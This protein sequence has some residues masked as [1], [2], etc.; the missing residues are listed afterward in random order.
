METDY[1]LAV[2][3]DKKRGT[4]TSDRKLAHLQICLEHDVQARNN[5]TGLEDVSFIHHATTDLNIDEID[6]SVELFN[7]KLDTPLIISSMTGGHSFAQ[8]LNAFLSQAVEQTKIGMGVG[9]QRAALENE[10]VR[11]SFNVVR[12]K[13]PDSLIIGNIGAGQIAQGLSKSQFQ[14]II[15]MISADAVAV[16]FNPL[17]E[18]IQPEGDVL[19]GGLNEKITQLI[20]DYHQVPIIAKEVGS[21]FSLHDITQIKEFGFKAIDIQGVGGTSW[22]G[23]ESIRTT[24]PLYKSTG[25]VFWDWGIPTVLSTILAK[26]HFK[27]IVI[28][29]GGI[30]N[31]LDIAKLIALGADAAGIALPFLFE[32]QK[33][34]VDAIIDKIQEISYQLRLACFLTGSPNLAN[35]RKVPLMITGKT[36][37]LLKIHGI[38][39]TSYFSRKV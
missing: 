11:E 23:V 32:V 33:H 30:R 19:L 14:E 35:L 10:N 4:I 7:K 13:A 1:Q 3:E 28:G 34:S 16:H 12:E 2:E 15:D 17:Q 37:E 27:G 26:K 38:S 21:G 24:L 31:G 22:A 5:T 25:E 9:S 36:A 8:K 29:S 6:L 18:A 39:P 20:R